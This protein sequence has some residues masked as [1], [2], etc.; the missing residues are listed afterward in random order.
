MLS[1]KNRKFTFYSPVWREI[2]NEA[3]DLICK[4]LTYPPENRLTA[5]QVFKH[6]WMQKKVHNELN[7][8]TAKT[9]LN[10]LT[11]F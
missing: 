1:V 6:E 9:L 4:M 7:P 5:E 8:E 2:S 11:S 3:K 10:N